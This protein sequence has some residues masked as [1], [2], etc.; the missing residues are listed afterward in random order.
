MVTMNE[1]SSNSLIEQLSKDLKDVS[2]IIPPS[3]AEFVKTGSHKERPPV[4]KDWWYMRSAAILTSV[5]KLGPIGVS[6]LR[7]K[8]GGRKSRGH[9]PEE[10]RKG[11]GAI[12]RKALQQL[13]SAGLVKNIEKG[14]HKGRKITP[15][16]I[17]IIDQAAKTCL[18]GKK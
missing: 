11:G 5:S 17:K 3:W 2:E 7:T 8:Y 9:K 4:Q 16:G 14:I 13:Q 10:F 12:I 18:G 15:A 1:V 6:K